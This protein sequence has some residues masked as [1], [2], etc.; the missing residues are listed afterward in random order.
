MDGQARKAS[1][2]VNQTGD[3][4]PALATAVARSGS[5][6]SS[7]TSLPNST[8]SRPL[9]AGRARSLKRR[10][11][12]PAEAVTGT[13]SPGPASR[14]DHEAGAETITT[15]ITITAAESL[16]DI[17]TLI[18]HLSD[19]LKVLRLR[20]CTQLSGSQLHD[21][22]GC[23]TPKLLSF[24][25]KEVEGHNQFDLNHL[26]HLVTRCKHLRALQF[27]D[28][29][30]IDHRCLKHIGTNLQELQNIAFVHTKRKPW[31][32]NPIHELV[33]HIPLELHSVK[34]IGF[35][36]IFDFHVNYAVDCYFGSLNAIS[37]GDCPQ[38]TDRCV[39]YIATNCKLL[40]HIELFK[41]NITDSTLWIL[42]KYCSNL[43][44]V[45]LS[46]CA[47]ITD[48]G[49]KELATHAIHLRYVNLS[50]N[51]KIKDLALQAIIRYCTTIVRIKLD[52]TS[53]TRIPA[54][55]IKR[56]STLKEISLTMCR[57]LNAMGIPD[58]ISAG[59]SATSSSV[60]AIL[61][62]FESRNLNYRL[63]A[64]ILGTTGSGKTAVLTA[65]MGKQAHHAPTFIS[66]GVNIHVW[67]P[68]KENAWDSAVTKDISEDE[69]DLTVEVW[70]CDGRDVLRGVH[71]VFFSDASV[72]ICVCNFED[73]SSVEKIPLLIHTI[74]GKA[75]RPHI[76]VVATRADKYAHEECLSRM[77]I[78]K[79]SIDSADLV[80]KNSI[81]V[82]LA[83]LQDL[84]D[85]A[86]FEGKIH[87]LQRQ[88]DEKY[89]IK[90]FV[91][92]SCQSGQGIDPLRKHLLNACLDA[93]TF[94]HLSRPIPLGWV[95]LYD[96][97]STL[98]DKN[99]VCVSWRN[100]EA[101]ASKDERVSKSRF[102]ECIGFLQ[103]IGVILDAR[104]LQTIQ[105][106]DLI[107]INPSVLAR[108]A[109][110]LHI[111][112]Q[113]KS[114]RFEGKRFWPRSL[115]A[116]PPEAQ[117][118][119][120]ALEDI[121]NKGLIKESLFPLIWQDY[122]LEEDQ[123]VQIRSLLFH[124]C[125][126]STSRPVRTASET[127]A[128]PAFPSLSPQQQYAI[129][130]LGLL[131][132]A[133]PQ[134]NW[135]SRPFRGDV[136]LSL[137][138]Y[139]LPVMP[140]GNASRLIALIN[141][142]LIE[143]CSYHYYWKRGVLTKS[144]DMLL[145]ISCEHDDFLEIS[146]RVTAEEE[147]DTSFLE[148][149]WLEVFYIMDLV[150]EFMAVSWQGIRTTAS[151]VAHGDIFY[152]DEKIDTEPE[153]TLAKVYHAAK[154]KDDIPFKDAGDDKYL[155]I[156]K[157]VPSSILPAPNQDYSHWIQQILMRRE[158][159]AAENL[160]LS[161][162]TEQNGIS[163]KESSPSQSRTKKKKI[164]INWSVPEDGKNGDVINHAGPDF[165]YPPRPPGPLRPSSP[166]MS[167]PPPETLI[168]TPE[169]LPAT[170]TMV[171]ESSE[172]KVNSAKN[173]LEVISIQPVESPRMDIKTTAPATAA[174]PSQSPPQPTKSPSPPPIA[175]VNQTVEEPRSRRNTESRSNGTSA[176]AR[177]R[178]CAIL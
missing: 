115:N 165:S 176:K 64:F 117:I 168:R 148:S 119:A 144:S 29:F 138:M 65:L 150:N 121:P 95:E 141:N 100:F 99:V 164:S 101:M 82:E 49:V 156:A 80:R 89:T 44:Y 6:S 123:V 31:P 110:A 4:T 171:R 135:T 9:S 172:Q 94:P 96:E 106:V 59:V 18:I 77:D 174:P 159:L 76:Y 39:E 124:L 158:K 52:G 20:A 16:D 140:P 83:L 14:S 147:D 103:Q 50:W 73:S 61:N 36:D 45:D 74:Y 102:T 90:M 63:K 137:Y 17:Q 139:F 51:P 86:M 24:E 93:N 11:T 98:R 149:L 105:S 108:C 47:K 78:I 169:E 34:F 57:E 35:D 85:G 92:A 88:V 122:A 68:F 112:D 66:E 107:C 104:A 125:L 114:F 161:P 23:V 30:G 151:L 8:I 67:Q 136:Q 111:D 113:K 142:M 81:N 97:V 146:A 128:L 33:T 130:L 163:S 118:L 22:V 143:K 91:T 178:A 28:C 153:L 116:H 10:F 170:T 7:K 15:D 157:L 127:L 70:D 19:H 58:E 132:D 109:C 175:H 134:L 133:K 56:R 177:S 72:Y 160:R 42:A 154:V 12:T 13:S 25:I 32:D 71:P 84:P 46:H 120:S 60:V 126:L 40:R 152:I 173:S 145:F 43:H 166:E 37:L 55:I 162:P 26:E 131:P 41:T 21:I 48:Y 27:E 5:I 155:E 87:E 62:H 3:E 75:R 79:R 53:I 2:T 1:L 54:S 38:I 167:K 129:P 69:K